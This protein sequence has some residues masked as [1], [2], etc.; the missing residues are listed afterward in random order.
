MNELLWRTGLTDIE[1]AACWGIAV[2][3]TVIIMWSSFYLS[4]ADWWC[5]KKRDTAKTREQWENTEP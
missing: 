3:G 1:N 4:R 2:L 5:A